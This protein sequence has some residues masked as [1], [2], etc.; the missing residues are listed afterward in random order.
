M[1]VK[2]KDFLT[3]DTKVVV[4]VVV[5]ISIRLLLSRRT[6]T[7]FTLNYLWINFTLFNLIY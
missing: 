1:I 5:D 4:L 7:G 3:V 6:K 2:Q